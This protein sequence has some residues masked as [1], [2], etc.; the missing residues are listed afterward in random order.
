MH[1]N[2]FLIIFVNQQTFNLII[3]NM[4][5]EKIQ[6][7]KEGLTKAKKCVLI[8]AIAGIVANFFA[9]LPATGKLVQM[10][11]V[12]I[13][14]GFTAFM[15]RLESVS[16]L[17]EE[18]DAAGLKKVH[19]SILLLLLGFILDPIPVAGSIL[20]MIAFVVS[21]VFMMLGFNALK[22]SE[23]FPAKNGLSLISVAMILGIVGSIL[24][25]IPIIGIVGKLLLITLYILFIVGWKK[26]AAVQD[27]PA[28]AEAPAPEAPAE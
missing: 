26:V 17:L 22:K 2:K 24:T 5:Q 11:N 23:T 4:E 14:A 13:I 10:C 20:A 21:F 6:A 8:F 1:L 28:K 12:L 18:A 25:I 3:V 27:V 16:P 7:L 15:L 9:I 19:L